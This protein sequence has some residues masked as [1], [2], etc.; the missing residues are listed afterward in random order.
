MGILCCLYRL[1]PETDLSAWQAFIRQSDI[2]LTFR[3]PSV[4]SYQVHP[5]GN[6][7]EGTT[8]FQYL[9]L[10]EYST[11]EALERDMAGDVWTAGMT[12]MY[13]NG[14]AQ[15]TCFFLEEALDEHVHGIDA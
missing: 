2:P 12:A 14:L 6:T 1:K 3:M 11:R 13:A 5:I 7:L 15:E 10:L 4:I 9:E 8:D